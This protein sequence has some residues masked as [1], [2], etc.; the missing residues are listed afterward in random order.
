MMVAMK[1]YVCILFICVAAAYCA[2]AQPRSDTAHFEVDM[3][4]VHLSE[5]QVDLSAPLMLAPPL[6]MHLALPATP[7][8][9]PSINPRAVS[10]PPY[11][12]ELSLYPEFAQGTMGSALLRGAAMSRQDVVMHILGATIMT[13]FIVHQVIRGGPISDRQM[14]I[15]PIPVEPP[16][17]PKQIMP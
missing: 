9:E 1:K 13:G 3:P 2:N 12:A 5:P 6:N 14:K 8:V 17:A 10:I 15:V 4:Q 16:K 11:R 7:S